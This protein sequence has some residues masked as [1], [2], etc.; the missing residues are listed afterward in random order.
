MKASISQL[1]DAETRLNTFQVS[2]NSATRNSLHLLSLT[3]ARYPK[4]WI[5]ELPRIYLPIALEFCLHARRVSEISA[6]S[7]TVAAEIVSHRLSYLEGQK[8]YSIDKNYR[9]ALNRV[10]HST[11]LSLVYAR[12]S[13]VEA[14]NELDQ[15]IVGI[16]AESDQKVRSLIDLA[17]LILHFR[18]EVVP[19][20]PFRMLATQKQS[21][22]KESGA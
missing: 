3:Q 2:F 15:M 8:G 20:V 19:K 9:S 22:S 4:V 14:G 12:A 17:G 21:L 1:A 13:D 7:Q 18:N 5:P 11:Y 10:L 16:E 6:T